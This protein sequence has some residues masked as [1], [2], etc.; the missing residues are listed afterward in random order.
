MGLYNG[1]FLELTNATAAVVAMVDA[2]GDQ[3]AG[4]DSSRPANAALASVPSSITSVVLA[5]ANPAR[6]QLVIVNVSTKVLSVAFAATA[7]VAAFSFQLA[8]NGIYESPI[9]GY[10]GIV[11]GIWA[12]V[13]GSAKVTE[14]TT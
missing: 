11:S 1:S 12:A 2:N 7:S 9:N 3:L 5:A 4:F 10:T 6:R 14:V 13:N 8:A